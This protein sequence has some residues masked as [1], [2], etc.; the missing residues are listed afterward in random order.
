V[1]SSVRHLPEENVDQDDDVENEIDN[2]ER[3]S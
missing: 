1:T 3:P 2:D